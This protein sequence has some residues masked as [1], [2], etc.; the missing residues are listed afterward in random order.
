LAI[1]L[2]MVM[3]LASAPAF[4]EQVLRRGNG[5]EPESLDFQKSSSVA[6]ANIQRDMAEGLVSLAADAELVPGAAQSWDVSPDGTV[7][8]FHIRPNAR[9]SNGDPV[10]AHDFVYSFRRAV[11]PETASEYA[12]ILYPVK[13]AE[14]IATG[15]MEDLAK[16]GA[17]AVDD[18]TL[19]VTLKAPTPYFL[20][21]LTHPTT[22][23][24][25]RRTV[26]AHG[27]QW[28]RPENIVTN[29]PFVLAEWVPQSHIK[30]ARSPEYRDHDEIKLD[31]VIYYPTEDIH[32]EMKRYRA[33]ELDLTYQVPTDRIE[34]AKEHLKGEYRNAPYLGV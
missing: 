8:T 5:T 15:G 19:R 3:A 16:L 25:H 22:F 27:D 34:W 20:G 13:N 29:G 14:A 7:Y 2:A 28:T 23:P 11:N 9:W 26:E 1:S 30:L 12:F 6:A 10:T 24:V 31:A 21:M 18:K 17:E 32:T 4:A 33:G